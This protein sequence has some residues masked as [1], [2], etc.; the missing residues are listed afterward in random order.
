MDRT[1]GINKEAKV[2]KEKREDEATIK[3]V[4]KEVSKMSIAEVRD[5]L[6]IMRMEEVAKTL[7]CSRTK[8]YD[9]VNEG[10]IPGFKLDSLTRVR[11]R[12]LYAY[13]LI[14]EKQGLGQAA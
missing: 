6:E 7:K 12:A 9:L 2:P 11:A 13:I 8:A 10:K 3:Q 1:D 5:D 4:I 14:I